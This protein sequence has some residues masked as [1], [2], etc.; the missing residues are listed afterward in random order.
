MPFRGLYLIVI[1]ILMSSPLLALGAVLG[2]DMLIPIVGP[3]LVN[4]FTGYTMQINGKTTISLKE[5]TLR[6]EGITLTNPTDYATTD[7]WHIH[8]A[9][10]QLESINPLQ[11]T[12]RAKRCEIDIDRLVLVYRKQQTAS[13]K[14]QNA[15]GQT[16]NAPILVQN[17]SNLDVFLQKLRQHLPNKPITIDTFVLKFK[18]SLTVCDYRGGALVPLRKE[19]MVHYQNTFRDVHD[20]LKILQDVLVGAAKMTTK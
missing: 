18:G 9:N 2:L 3:V 5:N 17:L 19:R 12:W 13:K 8:K 14:A 15:P 7:F 16:I 20:P 4:Q 6:F 1:G 11:K 10:I